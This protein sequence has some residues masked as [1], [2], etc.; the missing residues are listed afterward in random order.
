MAGIPEEQF[1]ETQEKFLQKVCSIENI[2]IFVLSSSLITIKLIKMSKANFN[3]Y[4]R[5]ICKFSIP[6]GY[7]YTLSGQWVGHKNYGDAKGTQKQ[8]ENAKPH[9]FISNG[10]CIISYEGSSDKIFWK[11]NGYAGQ[12]VAKEADGEIIGNAE[13]IKDLT[14]SE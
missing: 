1:D 7:I 8:I 14:F 5:R 11:M 4:G 6:G 2:I 12:I 13:M 10:G 3:Y 9:E